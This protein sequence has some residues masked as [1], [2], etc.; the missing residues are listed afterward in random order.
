MISVPIDFLSPVL[1]SW[2]LLS[3]SILKSERLEPTIT[4]ECVH[5]HAIKYKI[6]NLAVDKVKKL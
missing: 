2:K 5:C 6:K 1:F 3:C 4:V